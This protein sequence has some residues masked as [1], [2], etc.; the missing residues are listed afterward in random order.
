MSKDKVISFRVP[1][2]KYIEIL[3]ECEENEMSVSDVVLEG[4]NSKKVIESLEEKIEKITTL[5]DEKMTIQ[6]NS[7][8]TEI[9]GLKVQVETLENYESEYFKAKAIIDDLNNDI[10]KIKQ[11]SG[12]QIDKFSKDLWQA[13]KLI[14]ENNERLANANKHL[15]E[16]KKFNKGLLVADYSNDKRK[17]PEEY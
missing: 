10:D 13:K 16:F 12:E 3:T 1:L 17:M 14:T 5:C 9:S 15:S 7:F 8:N 6:K 11:D 4:L 2:K